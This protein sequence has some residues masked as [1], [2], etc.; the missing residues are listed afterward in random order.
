[1]LHVSVTCVALRK[2]NKKNPSVRLGTC[3]PHKSPM[4]K[5][6]RLYQ[7][8]WQEKHR[9]DLQQMQEQ[10][11]TKAPSFTLSHRLSES[12]ARLSLMD[13]NK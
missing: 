2:N 12:T 4:G 11:H 5:S 9:G 3:K 7:R 6:Q 10:S 13:G 1:M 8:P